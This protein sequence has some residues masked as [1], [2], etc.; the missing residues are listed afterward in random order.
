MT[1]RVSE[2][3]R[4]L[5]PPPPLLMNAPRFDSPETVR[6]L[7]PEVEAELAAALRAHSAAATEDTATALRLSFAAAARDARER[8]M[9]SE[10]LV[11]VF[12]AIERRA[13]PM[14]TLAPQ[15]AAS[16]NQLIKEL[17]DAYY[18]AQRPETQP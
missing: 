6:S 14:V 10:E 8:A 13:G 17:L 5:P 1:Q 11:L 12:K 18:L 9:R 2:N 7:S 4:G 3:S 15:A 16:R